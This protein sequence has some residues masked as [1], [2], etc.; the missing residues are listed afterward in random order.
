METW[1]TPK[2]MGHTS[3]LVLFCYLI[4]NLSQFLAWFEFSGV[5]SVCPLNLS[6]YLLYES[7]SA[8]VSNDHLFQNDILLFYFYSIIASSSCFI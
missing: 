4:I 3:I 6:W 7:V 5:N 8:V 1:L 2:G